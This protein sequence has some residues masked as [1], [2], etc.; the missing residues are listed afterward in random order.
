MAKVLHVIG[1]FEKDKGGAQ[2]VILDIINTCHNSNIKIGVCSLFGEATLTKA[3]PGDIF[4]VN[5]RHTFKYNPKIYWDL[6]EVILEWKPDVLHVHSSV[7]GIFGRPI[8][9]FMGIRQLTTVHNDVKK[10]PL[11]N[12]LID[13][14]TVGLSECI[15]CVSNE[16]KESVL[17][18][19]DQYID[20]H[21]DV[22]SISN[23]ID[24]EKLEEKVR[25]GSVSKKK[26]LGLDEKDYLVGTV[27][28][29]HA[30]KGHIHLIEAWE[31][32]HELCPNAALVF[33]GDGGEREHLE[34][35]VNELNIEDSVIFLG[36]RDDVPEILN[37]LDLFVLPSLSEGLPISLLEAMCMEKIII[38]SDINPL[39]NVLGNTGILVPPQ[40]PQILGEQIIEVLNNFEDYGHLAKKVRARVVKNFSPEEF[41]EKYLSVYNKYL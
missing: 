9:F 20:H 32:V 23:C 34:K 37:M 41:G 11:R 14:C 13:K 29:L 38:A 18:E 10:A 4:N 28:R 22:V 1:N 21:T 19:Y 39:K 26:Q 16:V 17:S 27:G 15:I 31:K 7:A 33:A 30:V 6:Y 3:L 5:F 40:N 8:A 25:M 12:T 24:C 2:R 35:I 36:A